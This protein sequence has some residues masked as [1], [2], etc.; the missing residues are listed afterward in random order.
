[1]KKFFIRLISNIGKFLFISIPLQLIGSIALLVYLPIHR[2]NNPIRQGLPANVQMQLPKILRWFDNADIYPE[3]G[4]DYYTYTTIYMGSF[5]QH[6]TWLAWRNPINYF[7]YKYLGFRIPKS[8]KVIQRVQNPPSVNE[9]GDAHDC[10]P[11]YYYVEIETDS[12]TYYEYYYIFAYTSILG[13][14]KLAAPKCFRFRMGWKLGQD[15]IFIQDEWV[16]DVFVI[17]P[18]RSFRGLLT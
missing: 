5:W 2:K 10:I 18:V 16:Q 12:G 14:Y 3:I 9:I 7:N 13:I 8:Y 17:S 15:K 1:M 6:Y 4:R 11:G